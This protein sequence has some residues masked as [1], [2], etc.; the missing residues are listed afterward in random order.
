MES[1]DVI[2]IGSGTAGYNVAKDCRQAGK[3]VA[4]IDH[5]VLGGTCA[6]QG[7]QPKKYFV[8]QAELARLAQHLQGKGVTAQPTFSWADIAAAK[9]EFTSAVP[10]NTEKFYEK[11]GAQLFRGVASFVE[12]GVLQVG[13]VKLKGTDIVLATGA[14]PRQLD[15]PGHELAFNSNGFLALSEL[16]KSLVFVGGGYI[17]FEFA[18]V[19]AALGTKVTIL[20]RT[21]NVLAQFDRELVEATLAATKDAGIDVCTDQMP[22]S[23]E[24]TEAGIAVKCEGGDTFVA[25]AVCVAA[26][27]LPNVDQLNLDV[28]GVPD[29]SRGLAVEATMQV[30]GQ[31]NLYAVGDCA[32]TV[33]LAPVADREALVAAA[34]IA[35]NPLEMDYSILPSVCFTQPPL[36]ALGLTEEQARAQGLKFEV[37]RGDSYKW[38]NHRR[39]GAS[40]GSY[41]TLVGEDG[42]LL[43]VHLLGHE[44]GDMI[45]LFAMV[46]KSG[47]PASVMKE[48]MWAYPTLSSDVK[49]MV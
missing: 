23:M 48:M 18:H 45:N 46:M 29:S 11:I 14:R 39:L 1:F 5:D 49:Y 34:N 40:H 4:M 17:S 8:V 20:N 13:D 16:P 25:E 33:S 15:I 6:L 26:G 12:P 31:P 47:L 3:T 27:R 19:A 38:P 22:V 30:V 32:R 2:V 43:G 21:E 44:A 7:C 10:G 41:K 9:N 42:R 37:R 24:K 28:L 35:G 36:A